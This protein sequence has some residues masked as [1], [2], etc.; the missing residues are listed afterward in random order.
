M[1][2]QIPTKHPVEHD[3]E[4]DKMLKYHIFLIAFIFW[5]H[6]SIPTDIIINN[7]ITIKLHCGLY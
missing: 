4:S 7:C 5:Q 3:I 2:K 1:I 6:P